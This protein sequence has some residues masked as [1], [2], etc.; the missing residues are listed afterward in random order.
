MPICFSGM[1]PPGLNAIRPEGKVQPVQ[2]I[3]AGRTATVRYEPLVPGAY[4]MKWA[5]WDEGIALH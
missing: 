2:N 5:Q 3:L 1:L 4:A